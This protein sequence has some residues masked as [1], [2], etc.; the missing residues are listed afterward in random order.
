MAIL[1]LVTPGELTGGLRVATTG[2]IDPSGA[3]GPVGGVVQKVV[4]AREGDIELLLVPDAELG[5]A[6]QHANGMPVE[7]VATLEDALDA[8]ARYGGQTR[9]LRLPIS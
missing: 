8:L 3:V 5:E 2:T 1:D 4:A 9:N 6:R 7:G